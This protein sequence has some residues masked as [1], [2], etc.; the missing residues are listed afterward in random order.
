M[1]RDSANRRPGHKNNS[2]ETR[3]ARPGTSRAI[4]LSLDRDELLGLMQDSLEALA[5]ELA[6]WS[7]PRFWR[8]RSPGSVGP[9][10]SASLVVP[11]RGMAI[12]GAR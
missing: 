10:T 11:T 3:T 9:A 8:M 12:S 5:V 6:Y 4:G 7:P 1:R 2:P